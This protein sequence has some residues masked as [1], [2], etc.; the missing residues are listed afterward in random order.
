MFKKMMFLVS[1]VLVL[2]IT[3][4]VLGFVEW[5]GSTNTDWMNTGNWFNGLLPASDDM[6]YLRCDNWIANQPTISAGQNAVCKDLRINPA[7]NSP[8]FSRLTVNGGTLDC[9]QTIYISFGGKSG[10]DAEIILNSGTVTAMAQTVVG[11]DDSFGT[12]IINGGTFNA[13]MLEIPYSSGTPTAGGRVDVNDG[14]LNVTGINITDDLGLIRIGEGILAMEGEHVLELQNLILAGRIVPLE[15][16]DILQVSFDTVVPGK[17]TVIVGDPAQQT[18]A[19]KPQPCDGED[20]FW[21][22]SGLTLTWLP[23]YWANSHNIYFGTDFNDVNQRDVGVFRGSQEPNSYGPVNV[24]FDT[25]Y[26]WAIDE[27]NDSNG[28]VWSGNVWSFYV[29]PAHVKEKEPI[30]GAIR[31]DGWWHGNLWQEHLEP[32]QYHNRLPFYTTWNGSIPI[33]EGDAQSVTDQEILYAHD[34]LMDYWAFCWY[35]PQSWPGADSYNYGWKNYLASSHKF[36][37]NFCLLIQVAHIGTVSQWPSMIDTFIDF[38][39]EPTY[40]T[41]CNGRPLMYIFSAI[42]LESHFGSASAA[43]DAL[44]DLRDAAV[45]EGLEL[46]YIVA[47]AWNASDG[48]YCVNNFGCDAISAYTMPDFSGSNQEY[49]YSVMATANVNFWNACKNLG[50]K[51]IPIVNIGWDNRP[52]RPDYAGDGPWYTEPTMTEWRNHLETALDWNENYPDIAEA[53]AVLIYAWNETDEGGWLHPTISEGSARLDT[54]GEL[55][56]LRT[57]DLDGDEVICWGDLAVIHQNWLGEGSGDFNNDGIVN[58]LDFAEFALEL[59]CD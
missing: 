42:D 11:K 55:L 17:T 32:S 15:A 50:K 19:Y 27:V 59:D 20:I 38:F 9:Y 48:A 57:Y 24:E 58:L 28:D 3:S 6:A 51:V 12:L 39:K 52:R 14:I 41:V 40:Q 47:L 22:E 49:P 53:N 29:L 35:Y 54:M 2:A 46:P 37:I 33:V 1:A 8:G 31:W 10:N 45:A 7:W 30:V 25:T 34:A 56:T 21:S 16:G 44:D 23:G 26:Y 13:E 5:R 4:N 36:D 43:R 18:T